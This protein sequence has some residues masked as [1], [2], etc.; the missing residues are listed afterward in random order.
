[1]R[2]CNETIDMI[3]KIMKI[4]TKYSTLLYSQQTNMELKKLDDIRAV[5]KVYDPFQ[6]SNRIYELSKF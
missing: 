1:M 6:S 3:D 4:H 2:V 5:D